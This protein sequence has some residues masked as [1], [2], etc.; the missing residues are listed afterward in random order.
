MII[1]STTKWTIELAFLWTFFHEFR[2]IVRSLA[3]FIYS[4]RI[5]SWIPS[6]SVLSMVCN[7]FLLSFDAVSFWVSHCSCFD[8]NRI[9]HMT[10][11]YG[12]TVFD[13]KSPR[14]FYGILRNFQLMMA[15]QWF[16]FSFVL[17]LLSVFLCALLNTQ[18]H[19]NN[20]RLEFR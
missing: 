13:D 3:T 16:L 10:E 14:F 12:S 1:S 6:K 5:S 11:V 20:L 7:Q 17:F 19:S 4:M 2:W 8:R 18:N 15:F 9:A